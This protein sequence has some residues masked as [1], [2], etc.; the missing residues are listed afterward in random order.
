MLCAL[1]DTEKFVVIRVTLQ[2]LVSSAQFFYDQSFGLPMD[3]DLRFVEIR[4]SK[5]W[6][7]G[8]SLGA[9]GIKGI[10]ES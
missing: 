2:D 8:N 4:C 5:V 1:F 10:V 6:I 9:D 7:S 3:Q